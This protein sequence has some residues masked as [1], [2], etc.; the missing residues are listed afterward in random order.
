MSDAQAAL[1]GVGGL[2]LTGG[3][4]VA[5]ARYG[6]EPHAAVVEVA[7]ERDAFEIALVKEARARSACRSSR[8]AAASR[9]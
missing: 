1:D 5:P 4:D 6:E 8:S 2:L 7:P 3:D 9:C